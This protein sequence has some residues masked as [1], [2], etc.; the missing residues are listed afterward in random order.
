MCK[1]I[2]F[3]PNHPYNSSIKKTNKRDKFI[4]YWM[5]G[6]WQEGTIENILPQINEVIYEALDKGCEDEKIYDLLNK[7]E[8]D[9]TF[10]LKINT[11]IIAECYNYYK[12]KR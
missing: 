8:T 10:R 5:D 3:N 1:E 4:T 11:D 6:R 12:S 7:L 2:Y 9:E